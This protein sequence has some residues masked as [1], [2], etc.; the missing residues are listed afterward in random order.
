MTTEISF[1]D[2]VDWLAMELMFVELYRSATP[3]EKREMTETLRR[4]AEGIGEEEVAPFASQVPDFERDLSNF[5]LEEQ[6]RFV[7]QL[8]NSL[9]DL[10]QHVASV[11][12]DRD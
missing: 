1:A 7:P 4:L 2:W 5:S 9:T 10:A 3:S 8:S 12:A 11:I 6:E